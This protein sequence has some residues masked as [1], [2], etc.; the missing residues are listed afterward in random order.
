MRFA[1]KT[2]GR[3]ED[4]QART[5]R[6]STGQGQPWEEDAEAVCGQQ[7]CRSAVQRGRANSGWVLLNAAGLAM[8][9]DW[10]VIYSRGAV[11]AAGEE[12]SHAGLSRDWDGSPFPSDDSI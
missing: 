12:V 3:G 2:K 6:A 7:R 4:S 8:F 9:T 1:A 5:G 10:D 11:I